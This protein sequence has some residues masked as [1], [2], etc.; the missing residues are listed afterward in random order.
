MF[1]YISVCFM[2]K[3]NVF[4]LRRMGI[5]YSTVQATFS[6]LNIGVMFPLLTFSNL[7][8]RFA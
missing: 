6:L 4:K 7:E 1:D 3:L 2:F 5:F 8:F